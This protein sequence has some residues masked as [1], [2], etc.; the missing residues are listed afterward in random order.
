MASIVDYIRSTVDGFETKP[1]NRLDGLV[2]S[3]L[4]N[5]HIPEDEP[6]SLTDEGITIAELGNRADLLGFCAPAYDSKNSEALLKACAASSRF[7]SVTV[8]R[9]A[10]EWSRTA[11]KQFSALT[12][13]LP[14]GAFLAF[15]GTDNTLVGWKENFNMAFRD[16]VPS[17]E[18]AK[19]YVE[20]IG[21]R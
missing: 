11:E 20:R 21:T 15:R 7:G 12:F 10:D 13:L 18:E 19:A 2:F 3:W 8:C 5:L 17:Q 6:K 1:I 16:T 4:A 9:A 14:Q